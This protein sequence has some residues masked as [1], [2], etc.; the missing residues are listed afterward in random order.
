MALV[1]NPQ[2]INGIF[3]GSHWQAIMVLQLMIGI[4]HS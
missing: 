4:M 3:T 2:N 1:V